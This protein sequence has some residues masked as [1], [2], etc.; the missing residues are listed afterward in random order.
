MDNAVNESDT[1]RLKCADD[2]V[3]SC[4]QAKRLR[5]FDQEHSRYRQLNVDV[6]EKRIRV[7][8]CPD[9]ESRLDIH[10]EEL[11]SIRNEMMRDLSAT[12]Q[13]IVNRGVEQLY[14]AADVSEKL[15][16]IKL[17]PE[18]ELRKLVH[19]D[20]RFE[21]SIAAARDKVKQLRTSKLDK[22]QQPVLRNVI[23]DADQYIQEFL[24]ISTKKAKEHLE[25]RCKS[26]LSKLQ[27]THPMSKVDIDRLAVDTTNKI[28]QA[29]PFLKKQDP[30]K[31]LDIPNRTKHALRDY[32]GSQL[33]ESLSSIYPH[34]KSNTLPPEE[35]AKI[36]R[37]RHQR[38]QIK[39]AVPKV[40]QMDSEAKELV[41]KFERNLTSYPVQHLMSNLEHIDLL[42]KH[43]LEFMNDPEESHEVTE[44][45]VVDG[46]HVPNTVNLNQVD[47][48][49][50]NALATAVVGYTKQFFFS[51]ML[52]RVNKLEERM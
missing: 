17:P 7:E 29:S 44:V 20:D 36:K 2:L 13:E 24:H 8:S 43:I 4:N 33:I 19:K 52:E 48:H 28:V 3:K 12:E 9:L 6:R 15:K 35:A 50:S 40:A 39:A 22:S 26:S 11:A 30:L 10:L 16:E 18:S 21:D 42:L 34:N 47:P 32:L 25:E 5:A 49:L 51:D 14:S 38:L 27:H 1:K 23:D 45:A 37:Q 46:G 41:A 31:S